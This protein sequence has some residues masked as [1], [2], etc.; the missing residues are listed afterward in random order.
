M[1]YN[2]CIL[3]NDDSLSHVSWEKSLKK[4]SKIEMYDIIDITKDN[5][6]VQIKSKAYD[7]FLLKPPGKNELFK[8]LYD[9]RVYLIE[10]YFKAP[11]YP[12]LN[13]IIIYENKRFFRDWLMINNIPHP[14]TNVFFNKTEAEDFIKSI[15]L[16]PIV[17]KINIGAS[18]NGVKFLKNDFEIS[19]YVKLAFTKGITSKIGP[20][21]NKGS[22]ISK[23]KKI[24]K[25]KNFLNQRLKDY[26]TTQL[27]YQ[28]HYVIL[29]EYIPHNYEWRCVRI[30][31][32]FFAHKK[33]K[34]NEKSSGSLVKQYD[35]VPISLLDFIKKI[36]DENKIYSVAIDVFEHEQ[37]YLVNEIQCIFGQSDPYQM[38]VD[39]KPG[40]YIFKDCTWV[41]EEGMFNTN[42][43]YDLRLK[44][45]L[46]LIK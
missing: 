35:E 13:E 31:D 38:L 6:L 24:F 28:F 11:I 34:C 4:S 15:K 45:A 3:S 18:G 12:S 21:I 25:N 39:S 9:E 8:R 40:R 23:I 19:Q 46:S 41:F 37:G 27:N 42:E 1:K 33:M 44:H 16:F 17:G 14:K 36:T 5:W 32:S 26:K 20:K 22:I 30:N 29:Q 43:S 2:I 10:K 7:L